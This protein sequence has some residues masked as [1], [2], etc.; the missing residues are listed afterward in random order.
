MTNKKESPDGLAADRSSNNLYPLCDDH[1]DTPKLSNRQK[2]VY[3][4]LKSE[5]LSAADITIALGFCDPR[6][7]IKTLRDKG[8]V[9]R[10]EWIKKDDVRY[11]RYWVETD[12]I[13]F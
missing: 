7:Y 1:K 5:K 9:V 10:D 12:N 3:T 2:K 11:K 4:L 6:S 13:N 8:I